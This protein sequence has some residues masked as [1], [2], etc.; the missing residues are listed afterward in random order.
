MEHLG[1][2]RTDPPHRPIVQPRRRRGHQAHH[3][4]HPPREHDHHR[5]ATDAPGDPTRGLVGAQ[6]PGHGKRVG[7]RHRRRHEARTHRHH[8]DSTV[9]PEAQ[10]LHPRV[11]RRLGGGVGA[12]V[13][14]APKPGHTG[15]RHQRPRSPRLHGRDERRERLHRPEKVDRHHLAR[16]AAVAPRLVVA[17]TDPRVGDHEID[18]PDPREKRRSGR[19]DGVGVG[20]VHGVDLDLGAECP[21]T[22]GHRVEGRFPSGEQSQR[23]AGLGVQTGE[24]LADP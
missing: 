3:P 13:R 7:R 4:S 14:Q 10:A 5:L 12:R 24:G 22:R 9:E 8:V 16:D 18:F 20:H 21:A 19:V 6:Q 15:D 23:P 11:E 1:A 17:Q 2:A